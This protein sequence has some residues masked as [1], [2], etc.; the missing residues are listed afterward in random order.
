MHLL[1]LHNYSYSEKETADFFAVRGETA[2]VIKV[3]DE[4][5]LPAP[6]QKQG[7]VSNVAALQLNEQK[8]LL[9][10]AKRTVSLEMVLVAFVVL[11][12]FQLKVGTGLK[13]TTISCVLTHPTYPFLEMKCAVGYTVPYLVYEESILSFSHNITGTEEE[14]TI[15]N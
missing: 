6:I 9:L 12:G 7:T 5:G 14:L 13:G 11:E 2:K 1:Y 15:L 3:P 8:I 4:S 10:C